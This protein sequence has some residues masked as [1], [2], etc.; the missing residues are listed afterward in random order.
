MATAGPRSPSSTTSS[1]KWSAYAGIYVFLCG[2][3]IAFLL[4][5]A[6]VLL[7][8]ALGLPTPFSMFVFASPSLAI[9][10]FAWWTLV[11]RRESY[12]YLVGGAFGLVT[13]LLTGSLWTVRFASGWGVE[14]AL[15]IP[16]LIGFV[17][18]VTAIAGA[19]TGLPLMY[20]RRRLAD[21]H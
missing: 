1:V 7:G 8:D 12:T 5:D 13:A 20:V 16:A 11:E 10:P 19:L 17:L 6:L 2:T 4:Y 14:M 21:G 18:G 3:A 15:A 9:G